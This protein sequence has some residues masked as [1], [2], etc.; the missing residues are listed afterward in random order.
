M[1]LVSYLFGNIA[2]IGA[3]KMFWYGGVVF[4]SIYA[5]TELLDKNKYAFAWELLKNIL[6]GYLIWKNGGWFGADALLPIASQLVA[7]YFIISTVVTAYFAN[8]FSS[9]S[10]GQIPTSSGA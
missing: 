3:P 6:G 1:L 8:T 7:A 9:E 2:K 5:Y 10:V 4:L